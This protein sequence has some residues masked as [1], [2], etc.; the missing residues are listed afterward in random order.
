MRCPSPLSAWL[1]SPRQA[2]P[3]LERLCRRRGLPRRWWE[4]ELVQPLW[5]TPRELLRTRGES[6]PVTLHPSSEHLPRKFENICLGKHTRPCVHC[7]I[8]RGGRDWG[9][10]RRPPTEAQKEE[11]VHT[12]HSGHRSAGKD[13]VSATARVDPENTL[14][15]KPDKN[16][17]EPH[18][19]HTQEIKQK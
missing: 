11:V 6:Y 4:R 18:V 1:S 8:A 2:V 19:T 15:K 13:E 7:G 3:G 9:T 14:A 10:T 12:T 17:Q 5:E 16:R